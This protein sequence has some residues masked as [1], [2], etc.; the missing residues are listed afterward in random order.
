MYREPSLGSYLQSFVGYN[1][2]DEELDELLAYQL[3]E[4]MGINSPEGNRTPPPKKGKKDSNAN[5]SAK[6]STIANP[7]KLGPNVD[8]EAEKAMQQN[9]QNSL[10]TFLGGTT[11]QI[12]PNEANTA[13]INTNNSNMEVG[14]EKSNSTTA[15]PS[16]STSQKH[17]S[18]SGQQPPPPPQQETASK[19]P[20]AGFFTN[21]ALSNAI[22]SPKKTT[23]TNSPKEQTHK[24]LSNHSSQLQHQHHIPVPPGAIL[25][26]APETNEKAPNGMTTLARKYS[27]SD[28]GK[29]PSF[30]ESQNIATVNRS[31][32]VKSSSSS[33]DAVTVPLPP[34]E[35]VQG[36]NEDGLESGKWRC[37]TCTLVND[38]ITDMC[39]ACGLWKFH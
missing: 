29:P 9:V 6:V 28:S 16:S 24:H 10:F 39:E 31:D 35:K 4:E 17:R 18:A 23:P 11:G 19:S 25:L 27:R 32:K 14:K 26:S 38:G 13:V 7:E 8:T 3:A 37:K 30:D 33:S 15:P 1:S 12:K 36:I 22:F 5:T 2:N 21:N 34:S 20:S